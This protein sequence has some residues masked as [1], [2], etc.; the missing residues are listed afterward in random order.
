VLWAARLL[1]RG[2]AEQAFWSAAWA[3]H[4]TLLTELVGVLRASRPA[5][6]IEVDEGWRP[7]R[8]L[9]LGIGRWG[10]L[11]VRTLVEEHDGGAC[12][13]RVRTRL[14]PSFVG[15]LRGLTLAVVLAGGTGAALALYTPPVGVVV[16]AVASAAIAAHVAWQATRAAAVLDRALNHVT[17]AAGLH[18]L[19]RPPEPTPALRATDTTLSDLRG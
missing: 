2:G 12:L 1:A 19:P 4:T 9:S 15:T 16:A 14:R 17:T 18:R 3:S 11:H 5:Q 8:D 10:W 6:R 7:D 13:F